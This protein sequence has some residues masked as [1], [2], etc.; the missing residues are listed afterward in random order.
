M[1]NVSFSEVDNLVLLSFS[2][3]SRMTDD[4][5]R[6]GEGIR[7]GRKQGEYRNEERRR[8]KKD[9]IFKRERKMI[10]EEGRR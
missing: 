2:V 4:I 6:S 9:G 5:R 1:K 7:R 8:G 10:G 3:A